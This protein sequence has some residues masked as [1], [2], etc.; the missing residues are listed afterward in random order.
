MPKWMFNNM[1]MNL[2]ATLDDAT[3]TSTTKASG[4]SPTSGSR[5]RAARA[6]SRNASPTAPAR[7]KSFPFDLPSAHHEA[8]GCTDIGGAGLHPEYGQDYFAA[9]V[10]DR[11][12][13]RIEAVVSEHATNMTFP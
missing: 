13:Y 7:S 3:A 6:E 9:C 10:I 5:W 12:S 2:T 1:S 8:H 4:R 11:D